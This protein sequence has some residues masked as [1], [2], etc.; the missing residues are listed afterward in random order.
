MYS[1]SKIS[2]Q[3][4]STCHPDLQILVDTIIKYMDISVY[5]GA[6]G[7]A[8]QNAYYKDGTSRVK[9][10]NSM[11]NSIPSMAID[12]A[13]YPINDK[14]EIRFAY[15]GGLIKMATELLYEQGKITH[16]TRWG[17]AWKD[18]LADQD[19]ELSWDPYHIELIAPK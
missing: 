3:R 13:P 18:E 1:F 4:K 7:E 16:K 2:E 10:P 14:N 17:G 5:D 8:K 19:K 15:L 11:H 12:I 6:R 9:Y